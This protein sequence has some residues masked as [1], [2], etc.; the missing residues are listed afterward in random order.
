[1][2]DV[3][4]FYEGPIV[5][6]TE[7]KATGLSRF[8]TGQPCAQ[9]H[10]AQRYCCGDGPCVKCVYAAN[11]R[12]KTTHRERDVAGNRE[13]RK[14]NR[15][16][17]LGSLRRYQNSFKGQAARQRDRAQ[18]AGTAASIT[19][20]ELR[21]LSETTRRCHICGKPGT[22]QNPLSH[23]DHV[24]PLSK[25]GSDDVS[26]SALVHARCNQSKG[27]RRTHLI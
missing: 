10:L 11:H 5:T 8:F 23:R 24:I 25:E 2:A 20:D 22:K 17:W 19:T 1:M 16:A 7:A 18:R 26:N 27:N 4:V 6:R 13:W 12:Y 21:K 15:A 3:T 9:G 14:T